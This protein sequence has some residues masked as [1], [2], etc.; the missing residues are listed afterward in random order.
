VDG[1]RIEE[2][3][4]IVDWQDGADAFYLR[5]STAYGLSL[6][7]GDVGAGSAHVGGLHLLSGV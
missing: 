4:P 7:G 2:P 6:S 3:K 5:K 1:S